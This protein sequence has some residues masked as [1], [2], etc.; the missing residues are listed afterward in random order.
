[1]KDGLRTDYENIRRKLPSSA[2]AEEGL[3]LGVMD[4]IA[5]PFNV[6]RREKEGVSQ[7]RD[8][9]TYSK[10][11]TNWAPPPVMCMATSIITNSHCS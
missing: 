2:R 10:I 4:Q 7:L 6:M 8:L 1:M 11:N 9:K 5:L 3:G